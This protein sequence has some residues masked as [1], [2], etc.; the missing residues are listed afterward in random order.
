MLILF[1]VKLPLSALHL[2]KCLE[3]QITVVYLTDDNVLKCKY[4]TV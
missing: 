2:F 1:C 3:V 4:E